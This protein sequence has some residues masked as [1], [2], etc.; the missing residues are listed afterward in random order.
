MPAPRES[1]DDIIPGRLKTTRSMTL[2]NINGKPIVRRFVAP[3]DAQMQLYELLMWAKEH[4]DTMPILPF[5]T[6]LHYNFVRIHPFPDTNGR[7]VR[8]LTALF[9][10][11]RSYPPMIIEPV[12]R[13]DYINAL[14]HADHTGDV[15]QL[16]SFFSRTITHTY[17]ELLEIQ[18]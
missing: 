6:I 15:S 16:C 13:K 8:L 18:V 9:M 2:S 11:R 1:T 7:T 3:E 4:A 14:A 10:L 17:K 12:Y 5:V